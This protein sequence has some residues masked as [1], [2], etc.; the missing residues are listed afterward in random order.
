MSFIPLRFGAG[1]K[2]KIV[3]AIYNN[4]PVI[5]TSIGAEGLNADKDFLTVFDDADDLA[6]AVLEMYADNK[7]LQKISDSSWDYIINNFSEKAALQKFKKWMEI[8]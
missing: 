4:V 2:G 6:N 5:T 1:I 7:K 8:K 3:E